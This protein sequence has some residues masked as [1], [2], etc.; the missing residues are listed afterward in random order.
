MKKY[1]ILVYCVL[2]TFWSVGLVEYGVE[3]WVHFNKHNYQKIVLTVSHVYLCRTSGIRSG[4]KHL[5]VTGSYLGQSIEVSMR[6]L[7]YQKRIRSTDEARRTI[8]IGS[9]LPIYFNS[10]INSYVQQRTLHALEVDFFEHGSSTTHW[11]FGVSTL[12]LVITFIVFRFIPE[13][14]HP[15]YPAR[16]RR[17]ND[18]D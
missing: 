11:L 9:T 5:M 10:K 3:M 6:D 15:S 17:R 16:V 8:K 14:R 2:L 1:K 13:V 4:S 12:L 7:M 18:V